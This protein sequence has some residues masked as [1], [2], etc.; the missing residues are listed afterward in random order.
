MRAF[1]AEI[2]R[3]LV[4]IAT[5]AL[6]SLPL[7]AALP[8]AWSIAVLTLVAVVATQQANALAKTIRIAGTGRHRDPAPLDPFLR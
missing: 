3:W 6:A 5:V 4:V 1:M 8:D 2:A 7:R